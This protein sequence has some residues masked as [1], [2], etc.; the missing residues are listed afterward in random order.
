MNHLP[1]KNMRSCD[2]PAQ[3][4]KYGIIWNLP[5]VLKIVKEPAIKEPVISRSRAHKTR[6]LEEERV[7]CNYVK[8]ET[9]WNLPPV[10]KIVTRTVQLHIGIGNYC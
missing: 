9:S 5:P 10:L 7:S 8:F 3:E 6:R 4:R 2:L 1:S